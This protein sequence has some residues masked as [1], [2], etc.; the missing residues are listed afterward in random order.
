MEATCSPLPQVLESYFPPLPAEDDI[1][2]AIPTEETEIEPYLSFP[3][4]V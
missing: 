3:C 2:K 4:D 1:N